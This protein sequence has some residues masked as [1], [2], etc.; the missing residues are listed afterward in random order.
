MKSKH[1]IQAQMITARPAGMSLTAYRIIRKEQQQNSKGYLR[2]RIVT[3]MAPSD[4]RERRERERL[5]TV[6][7]KARHPYNFHVHFY[8]RLKHARLIISS[9][10]A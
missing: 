7:N 8:R 1:E 10:I 4:R 3:E 9:A 2:G 5:S 6:F